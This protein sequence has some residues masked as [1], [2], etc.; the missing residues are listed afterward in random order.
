MEVRVEFTTRGV[1]QYRPRQGVQQLD[2]R[3]WAFRGRDFRE[4]WLKYSNF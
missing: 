3:T 1:K 2:E 4:A